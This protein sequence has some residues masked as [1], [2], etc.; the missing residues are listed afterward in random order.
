MLTTEITQAEVAMPTITYSK[1]DIE[2]QHHGGPGQLDDDS[3]GHRSS[4][5]G[6]GRPDMNSG[7]CEKV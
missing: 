7:G 4:R 2:K 5:E 1:N 3:G 6:A